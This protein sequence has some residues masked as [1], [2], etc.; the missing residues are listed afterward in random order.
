MRGPGKGG[1]PASSV[2]AGRARGGLRALAVASV[3]V[4]LAGSWSAH[5][6]GA[7]GAAGRAAARLSQHAINADPSWR[8]Y[9]RD[10]GGT[11]VYPRHVRVVGDASAVVH[12]SGLEAPGG[13]ATTINATAAGVP[14]LVLDLGLNTGGRVEV[15]V[16]RSDG[17]TVHLG[18]SEG[19]SFLTP[20]GD[21]GGPSLGNDDAPDSR[22]DDVQGVGA[23]RSP[24]IRG[25]ERWIALQLQG[26]GSVSIDYVRVRE[27]HLHPAIGDYAGHFLSSDDAL[28]RSWYASAYTFALDSVKDHRPGYRGGHMVVVDGAKRDRLVWLGDLVVENLLGAYSLRQAPRIV[29]DSL[30]IFS[31]QQR[32]DGELQPASDIAIRCPRRPPSPGGPPPPGGGDTAPSIRARVLPEYTAQWIVGVHDYYLYSGDDAF[33]RRMLPVIRHGIAYFAAN[34]DANGLFYTPAGAGNWHLD[35]AEGEDTHTNA[36]LYRALRDAAALEHRL[37]S[38]GWAHVDSQRAVALRNAVNAH[39]WDPAAGAF[40]L[41]SLDPLN[42]T[43]DAQVEAVLD[44]VV[45]GARAASALRFIDTHLR[46]KYG[47][48]NG[49]LDADPYMT[50]YISPYISGT[51]LLARLSRGDAGGALDLIRREWG[52]MVNKDPHTTVWG[53]VDLNG[54]LFRPRTSMA[55]G[56]SGGPVPALSGYV[57]GIRPAAPGWSRWVVEPQPGD[58]AWA[59]GQAPTPLGAVVSRWRHAPGSFVLTVDGPGRAPGKV[60]VP[61]LGRRRTVAMDG[62]VVWSGG[63]AVRGVRAH[64]QG[65]GVAFPRVRGA[66]TFAW[67]ARRGG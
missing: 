59:Q 7:H 11:L 62:E 10:R 40:V 12:R 16:T 1:F 29:R 43:Q 54:H 4:A 41:N 28:N 67:A 21:P 58:L 35:V 14:R 17:S 36:V 34:M 39:L 37:G 31:C 18:Y 50:Q 38:P 19:R 49:E 47:V 56:W 2:R 30:A 42:H 61:T 20:D 15:R 3:A 64:K 26:P 63:H 22:S 44:G 24:G 55:H 23:W 33:V 60:V 57:L 66:H 32:G 9:V 65:D 25:A 48:K 45:R 27:K 52:R 13:Q 46:T 53:K 6:W 51:E 8:R 5:A